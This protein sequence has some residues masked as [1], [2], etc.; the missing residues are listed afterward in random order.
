MLHLKPLILKQW[1]DC[2]ASKLFILKRW[3]DCV[4]LKTLHFKAMKR[5]CRFKPFILKRLCC[6]KKKIHFEAKKRLCC[7]KTLPFETIKCQKM[8]GSTTFPGVPSLNWS[9]ARAR[10]GGAWVRGGGLIP[11]IPN[12]Q[13]RVETFIVLSAPVCLLNC[14]Y[15]TVYSYVK[16]PVRRCPWPPGCSLCVR[17][18]PRFR[19]PP[20]CSGGRASA[21]SWSRWWLDP[22]TVSPSRHNELM[23]CGSGSVGSFLG[24]VQVRIR[25][26]ILLPWSKNSKKNLDFYCFVTSLWFYLP[27]GF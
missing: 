24:Q 25:L 6:L 1:S 19:W 17:A 13:G 14:E 5:L 27:V 23:C 20:R 3:S 8:G 18:L 12:W 10:R 22:D 26:R 21:H 16:W 2:V 9:I 15:T 11:L 7:F 4:A